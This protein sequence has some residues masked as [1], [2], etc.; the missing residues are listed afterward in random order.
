MAQRILLGFAIAA[1][2]TAAEAR[3]QSAPADV[4]AGAP[5]L[6]SPGRAMNLHASESKIPLSQALDECRSSGT[7]SY[8]NAQQSFWCVRRVAEMAAFDYERKATER[9]WLSDVGTFIAGAGLTGVLIGTGHASAT[10][11][12]Y[13]T[14]G[15]AAPILT[16]DLTQHSP[17]A[18]LYGLSATAMNSLADYYDELKVALAE[19]LPAGAGASKEPATALSDACSGVEII[20]QRVTTLPKIEQE[21]MSAQLM[22]LTDRCSTLS[23]TGSA[24]A[25]AEATWPPQ[26]LTGRFATDVK[27]LDARVTDLDRGLRSRP[28]E[29]V[30]VVLAAPFE[31]VGQVLKGEKKSS[32]YK[33]VERQ[34]LD[35]PF[36]T[37]LSRL[38]PVTLPQA[39]APDLK[40][41]GGPQAVM[42]EAQKE[43]DA[44]DKR[45]KAATEAHKKATA[46]GK[47]SPTT[48]SELG[49]ANEAASKASVHVQTATEIA[50][51]T[52]DI[53]RQLN[54]IA[55]YNNRRL[56]RLS[57]IK[58]VADHS[59]LVLDFKSDDRSAQL[60]APQ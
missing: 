41:L 53:V 6:F 4:R 27:K 13:W 58:A 35:K 36:K 26:D 49:A 32:D 40:L 31:L 5:N 57:R 44:A 20:R 39:V 54:E 7:G 21:A 10:T 43:A 42:D 59:E 15:G 17:R 52:S 48:K 60:T 22:S 38:P 1:A 11:L 47:A 29:T 16:D 9:Q 24:L 28:G 12:R 33:S 18:Q 46:G 56:A 23:A 8:D 19:P 37:S 30:G 2:L 34:L 55:D 14:Y 45:L 3:A 51:K 50:A 25:M